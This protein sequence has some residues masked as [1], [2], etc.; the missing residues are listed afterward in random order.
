MK[1][2]LLVT[3]LTLL[4][5]A[6]G[7][8]ARAWTGRDHPLP[9][10]PAIGS[11]FLPGSNGEKKPAPRPAFNR[12]ELIAEIERL[13]PQIDAYRARL[14]KLDEDYEKAFREILNP[15]QRQIYDAKLADNQ[16][17]RAERE[18]KEAN[19]PPP[20]PLSDEEIAKLRQRPFEIAFGR[21]AFIGRLESTVTHYKLDARQTACVRELLLT[22]RDKFIALV[23]STPPPTFKLSDLAASVQRLVDPAAAQTAVPA[24]APA[25]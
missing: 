5:F 10:P 18:A 24:A 25:K 4:G 7:F 16:K 15:E 1:Q 17:R 20:P 12:A 2:S 19:S 21:V 8:A 3:L 23:D 13:R 11:E 22:R 6:A 14:E 9:P